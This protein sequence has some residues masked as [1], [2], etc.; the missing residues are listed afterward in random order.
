MYSFNMV[1]EKEKKQNVKK[2]RKLKVW[3]KPW[4][5][6]RIRTTAYH[7]IFK[8]TQLSDQDDFRKYLR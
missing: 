3:M 7:S 4:L 5:Q 8:E 1:F 2:I 6:N